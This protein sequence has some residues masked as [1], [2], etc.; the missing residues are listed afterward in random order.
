MSPLWVDRKTRVVITL[1]KAVPL[2]IIEFALFTTLREAR[3]TLTTAELTDRI[4]HGVKEPPLYWCANMH[5]IKRKLNAKLEHINL[6]V[7]TI[8]R[9]NKALWRLENR[10]K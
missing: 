8:Q 3:T 1:P 2:T 7:T 9:K 6:V 4:Y 10:K 5:L